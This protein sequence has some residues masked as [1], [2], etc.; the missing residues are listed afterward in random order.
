MIGAIG[1]FNLAYLVAGAGSFM[2]LK[3]FF[4]VKLWDY[5]FFR[6]LLVGLFLLVIG[7][8]L[9]RQTGMSDIVSGIGVMVIVSILFFYH[10]KSSNSTWLYRL[11]SLE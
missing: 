11:R 2:V 7:F 3:R 9:G 8:L 5:T 10:L 1:S 4:S 6:D